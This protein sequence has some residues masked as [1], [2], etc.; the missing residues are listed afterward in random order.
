MYTLQTWYYNNQK[1]WDET[2]EYETLDQLE[3]DLMLYKISINLGY[4]V[5]HNDEL[6]YKWFDKKSYIELSEML[7]KHKQNDIEQIEMLRNKYK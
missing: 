7:K 3:K 6:L 5:F 1:R 4:R 2:Q